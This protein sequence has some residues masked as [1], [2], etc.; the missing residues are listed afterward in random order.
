MYSC[1]FS[2][3]INEYIQYHYMS[4]D[5]DK[6]AQFTIRLPVE[7]KEALQNSAKEK[8]IDGVTWIRHAIREK[9]A[10]EEAEKKSHIPPNP[11]ITDVQNWMESQYE[12]LK[13]RINRELDVAFPKKQNT[14]MQNGNGNNAVI[15]GK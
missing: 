12:E 9:L 3:N 6:N 15:G 2:K 11:S 1:V 5:F 8:D 4:R 14:I 13:E 10:R 7:L